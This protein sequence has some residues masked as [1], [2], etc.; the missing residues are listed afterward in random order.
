MWPPSVYLGCLTDESAGGKHTEAPTTSAGRPKLREKAFSLTIAGPVKRASIKTHNRC[1]TCMTPGFSSLNAATNMAGSHA[2]FCS[3][4]IRKEE[5]PTVSEPSPLPERQ[6]TIHTEM[7]RAYWILPGITL[8]SESDPSKARVITF[9]ENGERARRHLVGD[10]AR[11]I[12]LKEADTERRV[13][14]KIVS[15]ES[16]RQSTRIVFGTTS[17]E[18]RTDSVCKPPSIIRFHQPKRIVFQRTA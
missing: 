8:A 18:L 6:G 10:K 1:A 4:E 13:D 11:S 5:V 12:L 17:D 14:S 3:V 7:N 9:W 16:A 2:M 15:T